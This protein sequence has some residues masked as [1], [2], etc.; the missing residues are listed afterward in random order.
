MK[1]PLTAIF[2]TRNSSEDLAAHG[3]ACSGW[4]DK[5][6]QV[7]VV[8]SSEDGAVSS[9]WESWSSRPVQVHYLPPG[10]YEAWNFGV[11]A[12]RESFCYFSTVGDSIDLNGLEKLTAC[13]QCFQAD[14]VISPPVLIEDGPGDSSWPIHHLVKA[15]DQEVLI[16]EEEKFLWLA[17]LLPQTLLG[18][19]AANLYKTSY[20]LERP[21]PTD[22]GHAGDA[23]WGLR[24]LDGARVVVTQSVKAR[25]L[26]HEPRKPL[27]PKDYAV[28]CLQLQR[29]AARIL[30]ESA[31]APV[32]I[33]AFLEA[34]LALHE[35]QLRWFEGL[36]SQSEEI[37]A[38]RQELEMKT[39]ELA[40]LKQRKPTEAGLF[41]KLLT[42]LWP[43]KP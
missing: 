14:V 3:L 17:G 8:D 9:L 36:A 5:V 16:S 7:V 10:L 29:E 12:A 4:I 20:V 28:T 27:K 32:G 6:A 24:L 11:A 33:K 25:F 43:Q 34:S 38:L 31:S 35:A 1:L 2:P 23:A 21:F 41:Q 30:Q 40:R 22:F 26:M 37:A 15:I 13:A 42:R 19:S 18:S 39:T